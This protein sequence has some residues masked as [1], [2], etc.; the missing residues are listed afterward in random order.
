MIPARERRKMARFQNRGRPPTLAAMKVLQIVLGSVALLGLT[1]G[2]MLA[3]QFS[4]EQDIVGLRL[5]QRVLVDDG[6]CPA[7][8]VKEVLGAQMTSDGVARTSRCIA[9]QGPKKKF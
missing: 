7:G 4:R 9:R 6:T 3:Q 8:Q 1:T 5:G 2:P